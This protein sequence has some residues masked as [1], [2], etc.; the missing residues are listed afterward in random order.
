METRGPHFRRHRSLVARNLGYGLLISRPAA[1][2]SYEGRPLVAR[3]IAGDPLAIDVSLAWVAGVRR[4]RRARA[5]AEHCSRMLPN[6]FGQGLGLMRAHKARDA[7]QALAGPAR[8]S[9]LG[10]QVLEVIAQP[11]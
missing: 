3:R 10:Q 7:S 5:F 1:D 6:Q 4:T 11:L 8:A 9:E 2:V